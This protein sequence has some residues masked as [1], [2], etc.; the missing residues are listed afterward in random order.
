MNNM[1]QFN[2][3]ICTLLMLA[4]LG[5]SGM[6]GQAIGVEVVVDTAFYGPN[7]PTP[8]D[9][10]D[11]EGILDGYVS[12]L[13]YVN[14]TNPDCVVECGVCRHRVYPQE[15]PWALNAPCGCWNPVDELI[16]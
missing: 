13:V 10:F 5:Q 1:G 15:V 11:P 9:T 12:Y 8:D 14:F 7:T 2:L 6:F 3:H 16:S 4:G